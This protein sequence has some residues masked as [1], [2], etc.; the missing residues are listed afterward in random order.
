M[1]AVRSVRWQLYRS[2]IGWLLPLCTVAGVGTYFFVAFTLTSQFDAT[3]ISKAQSLATMTRI[4]ADPATPRIERVEFDLV[5]EAI[6]EYLKKRHPEYFQI[7]EVFDRPEIAPTV[8]EQ[9]ASLD[10]DELPYINVQDEDPVIE[11]HTLPDGRPGR[12]VWIK[13]NVARTHD[14]IKPSDRSAASRGA[15]HFALVSVARARAEI[16]RPLKVVLIGL[17]SVGGLVGLFAAVAVTRA[18]RH[19]MS[20]MDILSA[21]VA[22][23]D[24]ERLPARLNLPPLPEEISPV[25]DRIDELITRLRGA[26]E[27]ER[28]FSGSAAHEMRTP[29]AEIKALL[30]V[31]I[32]WPED[33]D[34][35][36][37]TL[38]EARSIADRMERLS[39]LLLDLVKV[40]AGRTPLQPTTLNLHAMVA[41]IIDSHQSLAESRQ[42]TVDPEIPTD[43]TIWSDAAAVESILTNLISNALQYAPSA[44]RVLISGRA[45]SGAGVCVT[46][47]NAAPFLTAEDCT[48]M[49]EPFWRQDA[50]RTTGTHELSRIGLGLAIARGMAARIDCELTADLR[51][52]NLSMICAFAANTGSAPTIEPDNQR[53]NLLTA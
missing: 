53:A 42:V 40:D 37:S 34:T 11:D 27:R 5:G 8:V 39:N 28:R 46:V 31:R 48:R 22:G 43:L 38:Q 23:L 19:A 32:R 25:A 49:F 2:L 15:P 17:L 29:L 44:T 14:P 20:P 16:D 36:V 35:C 4:E 18:V 41:R 7:W 1:K 33:V 45:R 47:T 52:G 30:D 26:I 9:S 10:D 13:V 24:A 50:A 51:G 21:T 3:L 12:T 6:P